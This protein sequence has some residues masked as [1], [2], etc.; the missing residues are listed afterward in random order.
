LLLELSQ[1]FLTVLL[2]LTIQNITCAIPTKWEKV[3]M[4]LT[5][6]LDSGWQISGHSSNRVAVG[7][8]GAANN[9]DKE[10]FT[11]LLTKNGKYITCLIVNP[12]PPTA[13]IASC[14]RLD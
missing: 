3:D 8:T 12:T 4:G 14:R 6:L 7:N 5:Q 1:F 10:T 2:I 11:C 13:E 9:Y